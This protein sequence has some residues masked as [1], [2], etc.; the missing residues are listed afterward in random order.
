[1]TPAFTKLQ[2]SIISSSVWLESDETRIVWITL[3]ALCERDG[4]ARCSPR[5]LSHQ[6][7]VSQKG[8]D[9][10]LTVLSSPDADSRDMGDGR[11]IERVEGG[12]RILNYARVIIE[13][14]QEDRREYMRKKKAE[15]RAR[16]KDAG[17]AK[18]GLDYPH[19]P[20]I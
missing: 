6:A 7:R 11:R 18:T 5:G 20:E 16:K 15:S 8:C 3:L 19:N 10:A 17:S 1:M 4:I 14:K 13:G 9:R 2:R 12:F